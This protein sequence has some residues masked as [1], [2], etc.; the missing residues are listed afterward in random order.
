MAA[1]ELSY[2]VGRSTYLLT[3]SQVNINQFPTQQTFVDMMLEAFPD[4]E[5]NKVEMWACGVEEHADGNPHYHMSIKFRRW[6]RG[7]NAM[8]RNYGVSVHFSA[9]HNDYPMRFSM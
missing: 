6:K 1:E 3:Y 2:K 8:L 4:T 7:K 5:S 9:F